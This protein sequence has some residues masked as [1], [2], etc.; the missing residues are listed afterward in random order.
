M[1]TGE[2]K[3]NHHLMC[4]YKVVNLNPKHQVEG[5]PQPYRADVIYTNGAGYHMVANFEVEH[6]YH[7]HGGALTLVAKVLAEAPHHLHRPLTHD[8]AA[9]LEFTE[10]IHA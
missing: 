7:V 9:V 10:R 5:E 4:T 8:E 3:I 6:P 2:I 1:L